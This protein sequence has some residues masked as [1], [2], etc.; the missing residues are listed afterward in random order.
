MNE[1]RI[2]FD[3][4]H[5]FTLQGLGID[6]RDAIGNLCYQIASTFDIYDC[7]HYLYDGE[8]RICI[9]LDK[10]SP[11]TF[12]CILQFHKHHVVQ[13]SKATQSYGDLPTPIKLHS[14]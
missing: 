13:L 8:P 1:T 4:R 7:Y 10:N 11:L 9:K 6:D 3:L 12:R 14:Q 2:S 5:C